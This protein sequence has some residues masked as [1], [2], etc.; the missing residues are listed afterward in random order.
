MQMWG[1]PTYF[2]TALEKTSAPIKRHKII[3]K[4]ITTFSNFHQP[5][6]K[7]PTG[8]FPRTKINQVDELTQGTPVTQVAAIRHRAHPLKKA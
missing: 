5:N 2:W 4:L 1:L 7:S 8:I 6:Q 3:N